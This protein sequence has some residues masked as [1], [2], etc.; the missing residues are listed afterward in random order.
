MNF[1]YES[2]SKKDEKEQKGQQVLEKN[3]YDILQI[4]KDIKCIEGD[5]KDKLLALLKQKFL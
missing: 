3:L 1:S 4:G 2:S 5:D